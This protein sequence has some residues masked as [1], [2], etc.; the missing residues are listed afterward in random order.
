MFLIV[1]FTDSK[2]EQDWVLLLE[3]WAELRHAKQ[4]YA[5]DAIELVGMPTGLERPVKR[6]HSL[7]SVHDQLL[8]RISLERKAVRGR[9]EWFPENDRTAWRVVKQRLKQ[10]T[11]VIGAPREAAL[12][13]RDS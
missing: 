11:G 13:V 9:V 12:K 5:P 7:L 2:W 4:V 1:Q 8:K 6:T 10:T 3:Q